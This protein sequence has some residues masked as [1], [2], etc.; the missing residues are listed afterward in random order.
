MIYFFI[1]VIHVYYI[2]LEVRKTKEKKS[3]IIT[4]FRDKHYLA[5]W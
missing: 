2:K 3:T 5:L 1:D 4:S